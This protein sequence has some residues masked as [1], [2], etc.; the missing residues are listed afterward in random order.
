MDRLATVVVAATVFAIALRY[1]G[2]WLQRKG[3][4]ASR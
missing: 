1:F 2:R 3:R 4:N